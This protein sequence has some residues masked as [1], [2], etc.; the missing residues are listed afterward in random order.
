MFVDEPIAV[1]TVVRLGASGDQVIQP[2]SR[3]G[4]LYELVPK[5][6]NL[7]TIG[8]RMAVIALGRLMEGARAYVIGPHR[9]MPTLTA[10]TDVLAASG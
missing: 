7:D 6:L 8:K 4:A 5:V 2:D 3:I 9:P 10:L 1:D